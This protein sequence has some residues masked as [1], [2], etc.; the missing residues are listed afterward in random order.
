M[1]RVRCRAGQ[2]DIGGRLVFCWKDVL[3]MSSSALLQPEPAPLGACTICRDVQNFDLLI[4][5]MEA[6]LGESWGDLGFAD[7]VAFFA[8]PEASALEFVAIAMD[9]EDEAET[10][11]IGEIIHEAK[12]R[13]IK[14]LLIAEDVSPG[15]LHQLLRRG[16]DEFLPYPLPEGALHEAIEKLRL[17]PP[18][19]ATAAGPARGGSNQDRDGVVLA[20][21]GL[22]GGVGATT[23]ATNIAWELALAEAERARAKKAKEEFIQPRVCLLDLD[24]QTGSISTYLDLA[25]KEAIYE[26]LSDVDSMDAALFA[27]ALQ[28]FQEKLHVLT[29]PSDMLPLDIVGPDDIT[30]VIETARQSFDFVVIDMPTTLVAWTE[31]VL[32]AAHVYFA[33]LELDMR[34]AQNTLRFLRLLKGEDLPVER[35]RFGMNRAPKFTDLQGKARVKRM[36][37]SLDIDIELMLPDGLKQVMQ[38]CDHGLP[39]AENAGKNPLRKEIMKLAGS[40]Q[41]LVATDQAATG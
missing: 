35:L 38:A 2:V 36:A 40:L 20:V 25:R 16:A 39:L 28:I 19:P 18:A 24:F 6:E 21:H 34:S 11:R 33:L 26:L 10:D 13:E 23:F 5:D 22:A 27:G 41:E 17:P 15:V 9:A 3:D 37:E 14:V 1:R 30:K 29:A 7:A 31:T 12:T 4:E 32:Q 8:Q